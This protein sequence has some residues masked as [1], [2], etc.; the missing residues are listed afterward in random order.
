MAEST[1]P[2][3]AALIKKPNVLFTKEHPFN[4]MHP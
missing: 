4:E 1:K 2:Y 3:V